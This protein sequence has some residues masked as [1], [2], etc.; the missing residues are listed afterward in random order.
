[1]SRKASGA[2]ANT[3]RVRARSRI[4]RARSSGSRCLRGLLLSVATTTVPAC[5]GRR[6]RPK[7]RKRLRRT[8]QRHATSTLRT[9]RTCRGLRHLPSWSRRLSTHYPMPELPSGT[10]TF[11]FIRHRGLDA[12]DRAARRGGSRARP[13]GPSPRPARC[14]RP[15]KGGSRSTRRRSADGRGLRW[16]RAA[17]AAGIAAAGHGGQILVS[18]RR[19]SSSAFASAHSLEHA[20]RSTADGRSHRLTLRGSDPFDPPVRARLGDGAAVL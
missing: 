9:S 17:S 4:A 5:S 10:V 11:L 14:L 3:W 6:S 19:A 13:R 7:R 8:G 12:A 15:T 16:A 18:R 20:E 2:H 1:M